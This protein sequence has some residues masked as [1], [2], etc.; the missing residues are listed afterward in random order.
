[1]RPKEVSFAGIV[2]GEEERAAVMRVFDSKWHG[3]GFECDALEKELA[4]MIRQKYGVVVNSGSSANFLALKALNLPKGSKVLT[5]GCGFPATLAPII[6]AG[7]EPVLVDY[8]L[9]S[10]N[11]DIDQMEKAINSDPDIRAVI[12]AHT[13]ANPVDMHRIMQLKQNKNLFIIE[14]CCEALGSTITLQYPGYEPMVR[15]LG[16]FGDLATFSFYPSHQINGFGGGGA[17]LTSDERMARQIRSMKE[18]GKKMGMDFSGEHRTAPENDIDGIPYDAQYTY[19]TQG[20]NM[21]W[22][23]ANCAYARVQLTRL[24]KFNAIR[25]RNWEFL[26]ARIE[27]FDEYFIPM[28]MLPCVEPAYF[29]YILTVREGAPFTRDELLRHLEE[30]NVRTRM[31]FAGNITRHAPFREYFKELPVADYLMR[32]SLY[33]GVWQGLGIED[34]EYIYWTVAEFVNAKRPVE[35]RRG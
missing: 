34:T 2:Q 15:Y 1:M 13:M 32:N 21:K 18:W 20:F 26:R 35:A 16:S 28:E 7:Y 23:D 19:M 30:N 6:H 12:F 14:D 3:N 33:V 17:V 8:Q 10:H 27:E 31:F 9:P 29:G 22:P 5:S 4:E 25:R 24:Q 11:I